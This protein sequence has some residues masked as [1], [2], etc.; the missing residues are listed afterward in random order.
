[1]FCEGA[2]PWKVCE[3]SLMVFICFLPD[4]GVMNGLE[5]LLRVIPGLM[6]RPLGLTRLFE[7]LKPLLDERLEGVVM[8]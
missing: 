1:M 2:T 3:L 8:N 7:E 5:V 4:D 6:R